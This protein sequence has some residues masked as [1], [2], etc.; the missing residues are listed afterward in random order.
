MAT[1]TFKAKV[2]RLYNADDSVAYEYVTVP[3]LTRRH[4]DMAAFRIHSKYGA[5]AN[6]DLF[7]GVLKRI[8]SDIIAGGLGIRLDNIPANVKVDTSGFL[9]TCTI[10][11]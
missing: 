2:K 9:A 10:E 4:C 1:I 7:A 3:E 8:R 11:V 5:L 6:S